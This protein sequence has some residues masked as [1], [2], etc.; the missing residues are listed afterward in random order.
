VS[1]SLISIIAVNVDAPEWARLLIKSIRK[2]TRVPYE[3][4]IVDNGS[5]HENLY[6]LRAQ[7][8]IRLYEV[9][10]NLGHGGG[11]D[12]GVQAAR[13][14]YGMVIDIDAHFQRE[15]W[16]A[17]IIALY[18]EN[19]KTRIVGV[20]GPDIKP[21]HPPLFFFENAWIRQ[22]NI[23]FLYE[24]EKGPRHTDS[25][26]N[27]YYQ[28]IELGYECLRLPKGKKI[29]M[30]DFQIGDEID[31]AGK[32]SI[33]HHFYGTRFNENNEK[34]LKQELDGIKLEDHLKRKAAF[35][36]NPEVKAI[37]EEGGGN[38]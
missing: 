21:F 35:F 10:H 3:I 22:N 23:R 25:F 2:F 4:I 7:K 11:A 20:I 15:G 26:Q 12:F 32:P 18:H 38:G 24:P 37:L 27:A 33:Y 14:R 30:T 36:A 28:I 9:G 29:Y 8:D 13:G 17:D 34:I 6:W 16:D 5:L 1:G 31:I 19:P